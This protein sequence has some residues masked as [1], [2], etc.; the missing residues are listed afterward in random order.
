VV[1]GERDR[2]VYNIAMTREGHIRPIEG[3]SNGLGIEL[4]LGFGG[5][6]TVAI[7]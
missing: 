7:G 6:V 4:G 3:F 2:S 5:G 1:D